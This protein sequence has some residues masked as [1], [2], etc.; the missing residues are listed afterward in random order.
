MATSLVNSLYS[1]SKMNTIHKINIY[2]ILLFALIV[3]L[4]V[5]IIMPNIEFP[6]FATYTNAGLQLFSTGQINEHSVMP[7]HPIFVNLLQNS[8]MVKLANILLSTASVWLVYQLVLVIFKEKLYATLAALGSSVYPHFIFYSITGLTETLYVALVLLA[9]LLLYK[10]QF[11]WAFIV[12]TISILHRPILDLL[13]PIL[14]FIF[15]FYV[16]K[17]G[18]KNSFLN[19]LKY[20]LIYMI[21]MSSWWL[22]QYNKYDQFVRLNLGD[23]VVWYS[24]N[25]PLNKSGGGVWGSIKGDDV[26]LTNFSYIKDPILK[27]KAFKESAFEYIKNNP[28]RFVELAG[29]KFVRF[30]RL[31]PYAPKYETPFYIVVSLLSYGVALLLSIVFVFKYLRENFNSILPIIVLFS[32]F[33]VVHMVLISSIRCRLPLEPFLVIFSAFVLGKLLKKGD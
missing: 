24:G 2:Q 25:N 22:H 11:I 10:K 8:F 26:N 1:R 27:N 20:T 33:T 23:G 5:F 7:L 29:L 13:A 9:F 30:W 18:Y 32:Y 19:I 6:D 3:R 14:I 28:Q 16:H 4:A 17:L 12:I 31:W 21:L 15:S